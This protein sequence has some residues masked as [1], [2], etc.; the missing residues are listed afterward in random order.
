MTH[1]ER[2]A[3]FAHTSQT[4]SL[5]PEVTE[6]ARRI[7]LDTV[8][9]ALA[10]TDNPAGRA[11]IAYG[12]VLGGDRDE[13]TVIG[14]AGRTSVHGAAFANAELMNALD[15]EPIAMPGHVAPY[16]VP[17]VLAMGEQ[18]QASGALALNAV[19][20]CHEMSQ[21]LAAAMDRN[22][23]VRDGRARTAEVLGYA[24]TVFGVAAAAT[25]MKEMSAASTA[26]AIGIAG[27]TSPVNGHRAWLMHAPSTTIKNSLM[28]GGVAFT[29]MTAAWMADLGHRG[30]RQIL[31][32]A[33][34]GY[35]RF[36][37]TTRWEPAG[38]TAGLGEEWGF[39]A[40]SFFKPY[41]HCRVPHALFDAL[42]SVVTEH[43]LT[44]DEIESITAWCEEWVGEFPTFMGDIIERPY[45]AQFTFVHGLSLAAHLIEPGKAWHAEGVVDSPSVL[46]LKRRITWK[47]HPGWAE[48][49]A[50]DPTARPSRIEVVARGTT[51]VAERTH[52]RGS[53]SSDPTTYMTTEE[54]GQ[55]FLRNA[56]GVL[57]PARAEQ[58]LDALLHLDEADDLAPVMEL[59]SPAP[60]R[61]R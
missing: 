32:D 24:S 48:A 34:F 41:P 8:G 38:L 25:M 39:V 40:Q 23:D 61:Q 30:D 53:A 26:D 58:A 17:V 33:E 14:V 44:P 2:F 9:C 43:A 3:D 51:F 19:A 50:K 16:V 31:D 47:S 45:D 27:A 57:T 46:D 10:A 15:Y 60:G 20:V 52:P 11:G 18:A 42:I 55:K 54:L 37:G 35:P 21:R 13:A 5:P 59:L 7:V 1:V 36:I 29:G 6:E 49:V 4:A 28:P 12:R 56:D 22:R